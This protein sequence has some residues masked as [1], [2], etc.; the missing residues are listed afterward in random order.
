MSIPADDF[1]HTLDVRQRLTQLQ[2]WYDQWTA[3]MALLDQRLDALRKLH[4]LVIVLQHRLR[5]DR[6]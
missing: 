6:C 2:T 5:H 3:E 4:R 1:A